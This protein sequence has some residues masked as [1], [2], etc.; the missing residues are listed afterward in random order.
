MFHR[1]IYGIC[2]LT[3]SVASGNEISPFQAGAGAGAADDCRL[4]G[5]CG[6]HADG[7]ANRGSCWS[8]AKSHAGIDRSLCSRHEG[9]DAGNRAM[10]RGNDAGN[11]AR[12]EDPGS[13]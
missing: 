13:Q 11:A 2:R 8:E 6:A 3:T 4:R 1:R 12:R 10:E 7:A 9:L 5:L